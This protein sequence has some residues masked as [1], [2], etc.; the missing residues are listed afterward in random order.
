MITTLSGAG[1]FRCR[2]R[3]SVILSPGGGRVDRRGAGRRGALYVLD[4]RLRLILA[5]HDIVM[6]PGEVAELDT[7]VVHW[8]GAAGDEPVEILG[9]LSRGGRVHVRAAPR[10]TPA[11]G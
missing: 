9:I 8:F 5:G 3:E 6:G 1:N 10:R 11:T 2:F 4:G 7:Q